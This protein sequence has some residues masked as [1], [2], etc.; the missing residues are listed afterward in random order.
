MVFRAL[1]RIP[2]VRHRLMLWLFRTARAVR[3]SQAW[4]TAAEQLDRGRC[5]AVIF[6]ARHRQLTGAAVGGSLLGLVCLLIWARI[7]AGPA[8]LTN[9]TAQATSGVAGASPQLLGDAADARP[10]ASATSVA[11]GNGLPE[12][13]FANKYLAPP[14]TPAVAAT[15]GAHAGRA[16]WL[17][18]TIETIPHEPITRA[19]HFTPSNSPGQ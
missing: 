18:G 8:A 10:L 15:D 12:M 1:R 17:T 3:T 9:V 4:T 2:Y 14:N 13:G 5:R 6:L 19:A 16:A 7:H 11:T